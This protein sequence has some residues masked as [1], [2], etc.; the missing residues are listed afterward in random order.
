M[1]PDEHTIQ[2]LMLE[3]GDGHT[4]YVHEWGNKG[5]QD[6]IFMLHGGPGGGS[7]DSYKQLF[8]PA[9]HR[10]VFHDQRG[11]GRSL[12]Y[13]S[14]E[15]NTTQDLVAD[16]DRIA[17]KLGVNRF[18]LVGRSW[19]SCLALA[20]AQSQPG[21]VSGL[22]LGGVF[23]GSQREIDWLDKGMFRI[24]FPDAWET[25]VSTVP[26]EHRADPSAYHFERALGDDADA[27]AESGRAYE[28]LAGSLMS[29]DDRPRSI[30]PE[31]YD[32]AS[33]RTEI[34]YMQ[35]GCFLQERQIIDAASTLTMPV[36]LIQGRYDMICPPATA[37]D[38]DR[39]LP[40]STL[41]WT[42]EG[43]R[44]GH[45]TWNLIRT[46]LNQPHDTKGA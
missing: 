7:S 12:P 17:D 22:I 33:I 8:D 3:V 43:H 34:H 27:A 23:T 25:Y 45:E 37:Y 29:L 10:V 9:R 40:D 32:V 4:L 5:S 15:H 26:E 38:L 2:E 21:R 31:G 11:A 30:N 16:I 41:V 36:W 28:T 42:Q 18:R 1:T 24:F 46:I 44:T 6:V 19:G 35:H 20:Y 14:L 13:G 39:L